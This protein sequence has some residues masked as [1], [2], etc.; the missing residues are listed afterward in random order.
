MQSGG[1]V[2]PLG[3]SIPGPMPPP[4]TPEQALEGALAAFR[5][6]G[7]EDAVRLARLALAA[8]AGHALAAQALGHSLLQLGRPAEAIEPLT[9]A[10]ASGDPAVETLLGKVLAAAGRRESAIER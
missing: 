1:K 2:Y 9:A 5:Q 8:D 3:R 6:G 4:M 7:H 10:L